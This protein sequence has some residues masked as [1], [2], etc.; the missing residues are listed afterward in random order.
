MPGVVLPLGGRRGQRRRRHAH[1]GGARRRPLRAH[2]AQALDHERGRQRL[3]HGVRQDRSRR[4]PPRHQLLRGREGLRRVLGLEARAQDGRARL[5]DRRDR[6]RRVR[7]SG[8]EPDRRAR[9]R[10][11]RTRWVRSTARVR[12]SARRRSASRRARS[13]S[14]PSYVQERKQFGRAI[15][16]F[17]GLQF[18]LADMATAVDAARLLVYRACALLDDGL[19]GTPQTAS[20]SSMAK[21][22]ASDTAMRVDDRLRAAARRHRLHEGHARRAVH[23]RRQDHPDLRG[24][25][26]DPA[27]RDR[28]AAPR[29]LTE[30]MIRRSAVA[31]RPR[32]RGSCTSAACAPRSTTGCTPRHTGGT[33]ILRIEDT[34]VARSTQESVD[35]IQHVMHWL[36][37]DWDEGPFLQSTRFDA[38]LAAADRLVDD[39]HAYEC[40]CTEAEV[41]ERNEQAMRDGRPPGYDGR[42]RDLTPPSRRAARAPRVGPRS[43]RFRT[44]D[45]GRSTFTDVIRGEVVGRVVD[46]LRL[47]DRAFERHARVLPRQRGRRPRHGHHA[48]AAGRGP[49]RLDAPRARA[50]ARARARRPARVRAPAA[51]PRARAARSSRSATARSSVEEYR[52][53]GYLPAGAAQLPRAARLGSRGRP[54]GADARRARR[55]VRPRPGEHVGRDVRRQEA[56]VDERRAH[57]GHCR[58]PS[59]SRRCCRSPATRYGDAARHPALRGRGRRSRR[60]GRRRSCRSPTRWRSSSPPTT[61]LEIDR[62]RGRR[63]ARSN[64]PPRSSTP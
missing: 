24:H 54:R 4:R 5:T 16:E 27:G 29:R 40:F 64:G 28:Q 6:A 10:A 3:L 12:S 45:D 20:A 55:R 33:F 17:Q 2:R 34:D 52:D 18:M 1:E 62:R 22:F 53:A 59:W 32:R 31:S 26:P 23:A 15:A 50:P 61:T 19:G 37:L 60:S 21:L 9:A 44:P 7:G 36:G 8:R 48:R 57:P 30:R 14:R 41:K 25:E 35:Q 56:R 58:S 13:T 46:D 42:C 38:Y 47:R 49:H 51:D 11:S 43:I 39:G 63:S